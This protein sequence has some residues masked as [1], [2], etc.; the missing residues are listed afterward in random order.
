MTA[1]ADSGAAADVASRPASST[2]LLSRPGSP[3]P[4]RGGWS[5]AVSS[6]AALLLLASPGRHD[7]T[8]RRHRADRGVRVLLVNLKE[9]AELWAAY[10]AEHIQSEALR[11]LEDRDGTVGAS[12]A[13]SNA[14]LS[15]AN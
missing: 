1:A 14:Q 10:V 6:L 5:A 2:A 13:P 12:Y 3:T 4:P 8:A 11:S 15:S 7:V 9:E